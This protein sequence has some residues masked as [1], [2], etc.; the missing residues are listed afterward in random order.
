MSN[1]IKTVGQEQEEEQQSGHDPSGQNQT[2]EQLQTTVTHQRQ[3]TPVITW[4]QPGTTAPAT[5]NPSDADPVPQAD[6]VIP[7]QSAP[8]RATMQETTVVTW[9]VGTPVQPVKLVMVSSGFTTIR[10]QARFTSTVMCRALALA[11]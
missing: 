3:S 10:A 8:Q 1:P 9:A 2:A 11:A 7:F 6:N 4:E 5:N